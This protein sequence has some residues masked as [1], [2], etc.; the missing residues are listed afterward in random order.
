[1]ILWYGSGKTSNII[2][3]SRMYKVD[4][5]VDKYIPVGGRN[6]YDMFEGLWE[7]LLDYVDFFQ[8][9]RKFKDG[10]ICWNGAEVLQYCSH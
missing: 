8:I 5:I 2:G 1:M 4:E 9:L 10:W 6:D 3:M 7:D